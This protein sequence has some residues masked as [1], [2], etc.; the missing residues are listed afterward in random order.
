M[1]RASDP[2]SG[3]PAPGTEGSRAPTPTPPPR[4]FPRPGLGGRAPTSG[5]APS[6]DARPPAPHCLGN[7]HFL[8]RTPLSLPPPPRPPLAAR[9]RLCGT[10]SRLA[11]LLG[12]DTKAAVPRTAPFP[13]ARRSALSASLSARVFPPAAGAGLRLR[14]GVSAEAGCRPGPRAR[15]PCPAHVGRAGRRCRLPVRAPDCRGAGRLRRRRTLL[16]YVP[17][18]GGRGA[19]WRC[20]LGCRRAPRGGRQ[21]GSAGVL[22]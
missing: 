5:S 14:S 1:S 15:R 8:Q 2:G 16:G 19:A 9:R 22:V 7:R 20:G 4:R 21:A 12:R 6:A 3:S 10:R 13:H 17:D 11:P 18:C